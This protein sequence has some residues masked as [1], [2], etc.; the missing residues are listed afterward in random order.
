MTNRI[1]ITLITMLVSAN[2]YAADSSAMNIL[3]IQGHSFYDVIDEGLHGPEMVVVTPGTFKMGSDHG[4]EDVQP[5]RTVKVTKPFAIG[6]FEVTFAD[7]DRFA[8]ET[9]RKKPTDLGWGRGNRPVI[10]VDW[11]D[12]RAYAAWLSKKTGKKYRLPTEA[13][14]EYAARAGSPQEY[15]WGKQLAENDAN[16]NRCGSAW[17]NVVTAPVGSFHANSL[18]LHDMHGNVWEWTEDCWNENYE[19]A[20]KDGKAWKTGLCSHRVVR[21]GSWFDTSKYLQAS[22]RWGNIAT[23]FSATTGFRLVQE[24]EE[25]QIYAMM[26]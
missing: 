24:L 6:K 14:W 17:D 12:T 21:S 2:V 16:C 18:G 4:P 25:K 15:A 3:S 11:D 10:N 9:G 8:E 19:G 7:Y 20:P 1:L 5:A 23:Y 26:D 22:T 13:E